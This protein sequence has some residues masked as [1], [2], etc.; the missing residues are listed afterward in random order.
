MAG[1]W[2]G[3]E[4]QLHDTGIEDGDVDTRELGI[5]APGEH[6]DGVIRA[7]VYLPDVDSGSGVFAA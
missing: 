5:D 2:Y 4:F 6:L 1:A 7:H 3:T